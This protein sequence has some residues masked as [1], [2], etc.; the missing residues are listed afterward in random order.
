MPL[1]FGGPIC[2]YSIEHQTLQRKL[3]LPMLDYVSQGARFQLLEGFGCFSA[4]SIDALSITII[5]IPTVLVPLV[6]VVV[7]Y[8]ERSVIP[9]KANELTLI[10][11]QDCKGLL[12][13]KA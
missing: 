11:S 9:R 2:L 4:T 1:L 10:G 6:S 5:F 3:T 13:T 7:F 12:L 8:C